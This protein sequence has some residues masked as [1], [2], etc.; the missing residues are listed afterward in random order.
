[1]LFKQS[2]LQ[3]SPVFYDLLYFVGFFLVVEYFIFNLFGSVTY[4]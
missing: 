4:F 2:S 1:M 3:P